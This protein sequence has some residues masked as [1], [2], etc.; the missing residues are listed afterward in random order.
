MLDWNLIDTVLLD[1]DGTL[2]DLHFDNH[3][4]LVHLPK[5]Y[6]QLH[7]LSPDTARE[8]LLAQIES[9]R[10][11]LNWYCLDYWSDALQLDITD[12]K[13]EV[14]DR[15]AYRPHVQTFLTQLRQ[16]GLRTVIVTNAHRKS[17]DL[18]LALTGLDQY[19]DRVLSSHDFGRP[20]E[21]PDFW[22]ALQK[23]EPF[24]PQRTLLIDDSPPVL[25]SARRF[26]IRHLL[27][28]LAPDSRQPPR[29]EGEFPAL[30]H[31]DELPS[32]NLRHI[33]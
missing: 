2:L 19:V 31:F 15:I 5:R 1:M 23:A 33:L 22:S 7:D 17:L 20:K 3:F 14:Q 13:R 16:A 28:V 9:Q 10:G 4:W 29:L 8:T 25:E 27:A 12:L 11:T 21:D 24:D 6:A 26:G 18:K 32:P 30:H